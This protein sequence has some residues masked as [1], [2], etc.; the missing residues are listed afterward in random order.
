[1]YRIR[2][3]MLLVVS[4]V[5]VLAACSAASEE[6]TE[7]SGMDKATAEDSSKTENVAITEG[8]SENEENPSQV[9]NR[10]VIYNAELSIEVKDFQESMTQI[11]AKA[12]KYGGYIVESNTYQDVEEIYSGTIIARVPQDKFQAFLNDTEG[13]A[14]KVHNR[15]VNGE[16]I[17]EEYIDLESRLKSKR[18]VEERLLEF[19]KQAEKTEDLLK[20]SNDL[21]N[22]QGEIEQ[23]LGRM[24]YL[25]N[26]S[27]FSTITISLSEDKI[28]SPKVDNKDL[29]TWERTKNQFI[30][31]LHY[32][33]SLASG[34]VVLV[35]GNIPILLLLLVL[36]IPIFL[37]T[38]KSWRSKRGDDK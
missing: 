17:T 5:L 6:S 3:W 30:T 10:M 31:S 7:Q 34:L 11:E 14:V 13:L 32:L 35:I 33:L 37:Y 23:I 20:I 8:S 22:V 26:Q 25:E 16:D 15:T 12:A 27:A 29:N 9:I 18:V 4:L 36:G 21:A 2:L 1:M 28:A 38:R 19:M 24:K